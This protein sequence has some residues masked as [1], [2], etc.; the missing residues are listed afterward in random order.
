MGPI[1]VKAQKYAEIKT[2]TENKLKLNRTEQLKNNPKCAK[3]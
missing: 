2:N 3:H 1:L